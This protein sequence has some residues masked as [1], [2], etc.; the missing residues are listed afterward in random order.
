MPTRTD[1]ILVIHRH[2]DMSQEGL[3]PVV[4]QPIASEVQRRDHLHN[5]VCH[6]VDAFS[7]VQLQTIFERDAQ[8]RTPIAV[9]AGGGD[10][11]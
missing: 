1:K 5:H 2:T 10:C 3:H 6:A 4:R 9:V 11:E 7:R 8:Q